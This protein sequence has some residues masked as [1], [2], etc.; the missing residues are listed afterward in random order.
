MFADARTRFPAT[1]TPPVDLPAEFYSPAVRPGYSLLRGA[2]PV[3][4]ERVLLAPSWCIHVFADTWLFVEHVNQ[5][6]LPDNVWLSGINLR[7]G[8]RQRV[9]VRLP[10][11]VTERTVAAA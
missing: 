1:H 10:Q 2:R 11:L 5:A 3:E 9:L 8:H 7:T 4:G 6:Y